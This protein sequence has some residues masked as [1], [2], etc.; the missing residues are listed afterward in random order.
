MV[1]HSKHN[2]PS[3]WHA[4]AGPGAVEE[5]SAAFGMK[6][7]PVACQRPQHVPHP[8]VGSLRRLEICP[9]F[10]HWLG[11]LRAHAFW[12]RLVEHFPAWEADPMACKPSRLLPSRKL[13]RALHRV[14]G[15]G[16]HILPRHPSHHWKTLIF[17]DN[18]CETAVSETGHERSRLAGSLS[19]VP[20]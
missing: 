2:G 15:Q 1:A 4:T 3:A 5:R 12:A 9:H 13:V 7:I 18:G 16:T 20:T 11:T 14:Q 6:S 17:S 10:D 8:L 19:A